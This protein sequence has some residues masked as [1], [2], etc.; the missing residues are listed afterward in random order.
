LK[1][2]AAATRIRESVLRAIEKDRYENLPGIYIESF[3][4]AYAKCPGLN[5]NEV[6]T[7]HKKYTESL[8]FPNDRVPKQLSIIRTKRVNARVLALWISVVFLIV[9]IAYASFRLVR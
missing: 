6:I 3:I 5:P 9:L 1:E 7:L 2:V 8:S 4:S